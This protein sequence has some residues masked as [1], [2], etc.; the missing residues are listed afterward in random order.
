MDAKALA[1]FRELAEKT[2]TVHP[3]PEDVRALR[4]LLA[5]HPGL[6]RIAGDVARQSMRRLI[7]YATGGTTLVQES[8]AEG[9]RE[10]RKGLGY[11]TAPQLERLLIEQVTLCWVRLSISEAALTDATARPSE[12]A[13]SFW[14]ARVNSAQRRYLQAC[15]ALARVRRLG[16]RT[17]ELVQINVAERQVNVGG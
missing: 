9:V 7:E 4:Q 1:R 15:E 13:V 10:L 2:N 11:E 16:Q 17:P 3:E 6:W 5:E 14:E 8:V 12:R